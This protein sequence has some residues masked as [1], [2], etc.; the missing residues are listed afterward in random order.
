VNP[1]IQFQKYL[2]MKNFF[3]VH[4]PVIAMLHLA[5]LP[6][7]PGFTSLA[8]V[9]DLA[10]SDLQKL[11]NGGVNG[12]LIENWHEDSDT[13]QT[14]P[15]TADAMLSIIQKLKPSFTIPFGINILN[16][17]YQQ[18]FRIASLTG[19]SFV[20]LDVFVDHVRSDFHYSNKGKN[21]PFDIHVDVQDVQNV[22]HQYG[23]DDTPLWVFIQPKHYTMIDPN[24]TIEMSALEAQKAGANGILITK[25]TGTAPDIERIKR[26]KRATPNIPVGIGSGLS[27]EN[28]DEFMPVVDFVVVGSATKVDGNVDN[29]VDEK[30]V[31]ALMSVMR[32]Y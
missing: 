25:A 18:A 12:I 14:N 5:G 17:D 31:T 3:P 8:D 29:P 16:N 30:R 4:K 13:P 15:E 20:E 23:L 6:S 1:A 24:K 26:V 28:A 21:N 7:Q 9:Y 32:Q 27:T 2:S 19:A 10:L 22:R 11:Q